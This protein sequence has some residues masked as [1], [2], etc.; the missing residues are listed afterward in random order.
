MQ[1][2]HPDLWTVDA[3][4]RFLGLEVGARMT[5]V[6]LPDARLLLH[7]PITKTSELV[8]SVEALG[9]VACIV[10]PNKLHHLYVAEWQRAF[11]DASL[12]VAPGLETKRKDLAIDGILGDAPEP[13]WADVLDQ[14]RLAGIPFTN[15]VVFFHRP[16]ATLILSDLAFNFGEHSPPFTRLVARLGGTLGRVSPTALERLLVRD[17]AAFRRCLDRI[18][19]W[20]FERIVVAHGD[21]AETGGREELR[22][23]YAWLLGD[24]PGAST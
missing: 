8:R 14:V 22:E 2:L 13:G 3:P 21:V 4:L 6:R 18:L 11:P 19:A 1:Q 5:V 23:G 17:R 9:A 10:A 20:P 15:E 16:S 24:G 7:S 12:Y